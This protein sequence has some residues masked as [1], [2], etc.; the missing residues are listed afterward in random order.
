MSKQKTATFIIYT[1][2]GTSKPTRALNIEYKRRCLASFGGQDEA[3]LI[4]KA[5]TWAQNQG[6][7]KTQ[8]R[9]IVGA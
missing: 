4:A 6:F 5:I 7:T 8:M 2:F 1:P 3:E 9:Y